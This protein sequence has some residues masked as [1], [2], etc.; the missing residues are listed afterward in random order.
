MFD[1]CVANLVHDSRLVQN[2]YF[3]KENFPKKKI[4][5]QIKI[6]KLS[7]LMR[8]ME[9]F[10]PHAASWTRIDLFVDIYKKDLYF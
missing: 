4:T 2:V 10:L 5:K 1:K 8:S 6:T 3:E 7:M 9:R